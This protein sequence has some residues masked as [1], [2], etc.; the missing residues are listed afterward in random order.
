MYQDICICGA[1]SQTTVAQLE[2]G[3]NKLFRTLISAFLKFCYPKT[4]SPW[5]CA[6]WKLVLTP[7][8]DFCFWRGS[9]QKIIASV[10]HI[11]SLDLISN[12][13]HIPHFSFPRTNVALSLCVWGGLYVYVFM[14]YI[15]F[16]YLNVCGC[17]HMWRWRQ[18]VDIF[19]VIFQRQEL[20]LELISLTKLTGR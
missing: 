11:V 20:T 8:Q 10:L 16:P 14:R 17:A 5:V 3:N 2:G 9:S 18:I 12:V 6:L 19:L 1:A 4:A 15:A 7:N 13:F